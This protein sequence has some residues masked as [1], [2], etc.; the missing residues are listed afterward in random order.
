MILIKNANLIS[1]AETN[2]KKTDILTEGT[3]ILKVGKLNVS[4]Y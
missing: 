1:M 2:Y 3:K 4:D